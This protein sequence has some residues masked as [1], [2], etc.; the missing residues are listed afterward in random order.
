MRAKLND[1]QTQKL[2][3]IEGQL[4]AE[5]RKFVEA[6]LQS[7]QDEQRKTWLKNFEEFDKQFAEC[8]TDEQKTALIPRTAPAT[9]APR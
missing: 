7:P 8:L 4:A 2:K 6:T 5:R 1:E 3:E 9:R